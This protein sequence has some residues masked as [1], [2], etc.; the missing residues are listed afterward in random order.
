MEQYRADWEEWHDSRIAGLATP[1]G[2]LS[3]TGLIW[4]AEGDE[5]TLREIPGTFT[6]SNDW[7]HFDPA[8]GGSTGPTAAA[9]DVME[10][11]I[12]FPRA[13]RVQVVRSADT[14]RLSVWLPQGASLNWLTDGPVVIEALNRDGY[15]GLRIRDSRSKLLGS[16][17]DIPTFELDRS[18][19]AQGQFTPYAQPELRRIDTAAP[20]LQINTYVVGTV[21]FDLHGTTHTLLATGHP[22]TGLHLDFYDGTNGGTT[23]QWRRLSIGTPDSSGRVIVDFNRA[24]NY[25]M[26]FTPFATCPAP[27]PENRISEPITAGEQAPRQTLS[28]NGLR[29]PIVIVETSDDL[30]FGR[31]LDQLA[32]GG[33][34]CDFVRL[35]EGEQLPSL[36]GY[37]GVII[38]GFA[39][40]EQEQ[41]WTVSRD[42]V[43]DFLDDAMG[44]HIP[45]IAV[46]D[47]CRLLEVAAGAQVDGGDLP[48]PQS[49]VSE[50]DS[51]E[52]SLSDDVAEDAL[53]RNLVTSPNAPLGRLR[54][55][56]E[57]EDD[58][59]IRSW[60]DLVNR[61]I[62]MLHTERS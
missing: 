43:I 58:S 37:Q 31:T 56:A 17:I 26:A 47:A 52:V 8:P 39:C 15:M 19:A 12:T 38:F 41:R 50:A 55:S 3:L 45:T 34:H 35:H 36:I 46:G 28:E 62:R 25:P 24:V 53:F 59:L 5:R 57:G 13:E 9:L 11:D 29:T 22:E 48:L 20:G 30:F 1:N 32:E 33:I 21:E 44:S 7:L 18:F 61:F 10:D 4:L 49:L 14:G 54:A 60:N 2:W 27:V 40:A 6:R 23:S 51:V 42:D 16:F